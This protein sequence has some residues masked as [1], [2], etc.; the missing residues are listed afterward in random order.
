MKILV[1]VISVIAFS[2][3]LAGGSVL[4]SRSLILPAVMI[5]PSMTWF[6]ILAWVNK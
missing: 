1:N 6:G 4:D 5:I 3:I 2:G